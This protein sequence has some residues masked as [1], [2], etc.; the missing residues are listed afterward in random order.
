MPK[1]GGPDRG[2]G[3]RYG[4][5]AKTNRRR[6]HRRDGPSLRDWPEPRP[7]DVFFKDVANRGPKKPIESTAIKSPTK[8]TPTRSFRGAALKNSVAIVYLAIS[9]SSKTG[10]FCAPALTFDKEKCLL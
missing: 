5:A 9:P 2:H 6:A 10:A 3:A 4:P 8:S 7:R 1:R